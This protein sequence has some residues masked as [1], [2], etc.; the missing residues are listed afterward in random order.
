MNRRDEITK[1]GVPA[2]HREDARSGEAGGQPG[3]PLRIA[4]CGFE[5]AQDRVRQST[6]LKLKLHSCLTQISNIHQTPLNV[7]SEIL[8]WS[9]QVIH[10]ISG[11][12]VLYFGGHIFFKVPVHVSKMGTSVRLSSFLKKET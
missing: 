6:R 12:E 4:E 1:T 9:Q 10:E 5:I 11:L 7:K 3:R 8:K 2:R